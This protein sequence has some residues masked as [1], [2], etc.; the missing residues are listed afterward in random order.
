LFSLLLSTAYGTC[1]ESK[2]YRNFLSKCWGKSKDACQSSK[3]CKY[4]PN[5]AACTSTEA[6]EAAYVTGG[7]TGSI[8]A[9]NYCGKFYTREACGKAGTV[10][11]D[12]KV[13]RK[14][15]EDN[16]PKAFAG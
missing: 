15:L 16:V 2:T 11:F 7:D 1:D 5:E 10:A 8:S 4:W 9:E 12:P 13:T 3:I 6:A 14:Y